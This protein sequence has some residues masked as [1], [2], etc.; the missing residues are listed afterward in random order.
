MRSL[1]KVA[2]CVGVEGTFKVV[3]DFFGY[4]TGA[5]QEISVSR[6]IRLMHRDHVSVNLILVGVESF[7]YADLVEI[8]R[9]M[10]FM[11]DTLA[12]VEFG[13]GP[14][15]WFQISTDDA[16]GHEHIVDDGEAKDLTQ[17]WTVD[18]SAMDVFVVLTYAGS[19]VG[20]APRKGP[21]AKNSAFRMT[22]V[23]LAIEGSPE[24]TGFVLAREVCRYMGLKDSENDNN[25]MFPTVPNGGHLTWEQRGDLDSF[26]TY[27]CGADVDLGG[28]YT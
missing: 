20:T 8:D 21:T 9:A 17:E 3:R 7:A 16:N 24:V 4:A 6:Q 22:G 14:A 10:A 2:D 23:V 25:L 1:R 5:P 13:V 15:G 28:G 11:R 27:P 26:R 19:S 12:A 18:N